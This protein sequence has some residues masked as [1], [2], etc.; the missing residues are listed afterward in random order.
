MK[1]KKIVA[2]EFLFL[3]S[4]SILLG[5]IFIGLKVYNASKEAK[6]ESL[7]TENKLVENKFKK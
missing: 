6:I 2:R 1:I 3:L 4:T 5:L 7:R